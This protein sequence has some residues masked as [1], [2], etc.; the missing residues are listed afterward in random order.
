MKEAQ[1][2]V[3][4]ILIS[5]THWD[6]TQGFAFFAPAAR[7]GNSFIIYAAPSADKGVLE[8]FAQQMDYLNF[9]ISLDDRASNMV[10]REI[11]EEV[12]SL[13]DVQV[14]SQYLNHTILTL[15]YRISCGGVT[16]VYA[17]DHEPFSPSLYRSGVVNPKRSDIVLAGDRK[18]V[19]FLVDA[20]LVIHDAQYTAAEMGTKRNWG[21]SSLEYALD[22]CM[23]AGAKRLA[24]MHHDP[25]RSDD[26][27]ERLEI[28]AQARARE[29]GSDMQ[30][31]A[32]AEGM[33][34]V[35]RETDGTAPTSE[36][37]HVSASRRLPARVLVVDDDP[38]MVHYVGLVLSRDGY[39]ILT[40]VDGRQAL[41]IIRREHPD[42]ILLDLMMPEMDGFQVLQ[43]LRATAEFRE[44]PVIMF[45]AKAGEDDIVRGFE[46]GVTDYIDK[47]AASSVLRSR[48]RRWLL[49]RE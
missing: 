27:I 40:A 4:T 32:A 26:A 46:G 42:L 8:V 39:E 12:F 2:I 44:T 48:V 23:A 16:I 17:T 41:D 15:A 36:S 19:E 22:V 3:A 37:G 21:H 5:H 35:L 6:H 9:P 45:T 24:F 31:F 29:M 30:V 38:A 10:F 33:H 47:P 1:P 25:D 18:H 28:S 7:H 34:V 20:D 49:S 11:G 43:H 13:G 14:R